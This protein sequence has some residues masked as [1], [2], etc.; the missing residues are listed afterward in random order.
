MDDKAQSVKE[1][2]ERL[3]RETAETAVELQLA[4][5]GVGEPVHFSQIEAAAHH[6]GTRLSC[7]I[8][9]RRAREVAASS[10]TAAPCPK[11]GT[12]CGLTVVSRTINSADGP[13]EISE[14]KGYCTR[15]RRAFFPSA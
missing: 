12:C 4:E 13:I 15:C 10:P 1:K 8:Q 2:L 11:C 5:G 6:V 7:C 9:E 14:P 3:F